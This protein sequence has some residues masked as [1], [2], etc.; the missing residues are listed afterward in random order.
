ML[1]LNFGQG[2]EVEV[3]PHFEAEAWSKFL[4]SSGVEI[5]KF[6]LGRNFEYEVWSRFSGCSLVHILR[7]WSRSS[8]FWSTVQLEM[9]FYC[10]HFRLI[11]FHSR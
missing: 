9:F 4:R 10:D 1:K 6:K 2:F 5:F 7:L 8:Y 11:L 3:W